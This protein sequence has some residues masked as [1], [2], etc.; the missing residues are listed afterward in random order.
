M[1]EVEVRLPVQHVLPGGKEGG[2]IQIA[3]TVYLP[4]DPGAEP[5]TVVFGYPGGGYNRRYFDLRIPGAGLSYSE[6]AWHTGRGLIYVS[7][8]HLGVGDSDMPG[9]PLGYDDVARANAASARSIVTG[10]RAGSLVAGTGPLEISAVV[11]AGQS[12][13]GFLLTLAQAIDPVFDGVAFLGWSGV[14][15]LAPWTTTS[16]LAGV[17]G[18]GAV[19]ARDNPR[20]PYFFRPDVPENVVDQELERVAGRAGSGRPWGAAHYPGGPALRQ[21]RDVLGAGVVAAEAAALVVPVLVAVGDVDVVGDLAQEATAYPAC[22][23]LTL[24]H[25]ADMGHMHNFASSRTLLWR[26]LGCWV[27][28]VA[29]SV[30]ARRR[31]DTGRPGRPP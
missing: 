20:G 5:R 8:D 15:T 6:A 21:N 9:E 31:G 19:A 14:Q 28:T 24:C 29:E 27:A 18:W 2:Q 25:F 10:L 1:R 4:P 13:G 23:D 22:S 12:F 17:E 30:G 26:R 7:C 3:A 11:A 16:A